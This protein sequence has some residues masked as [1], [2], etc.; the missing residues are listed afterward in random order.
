MKYGNIREEELKNRVE[1]DFFDR[2]DCAAIVGNIDFAVCS[3]NR[4]DSDAEYLLWAEAKAACTDILAMLAQLVL[5]IGKARTFD[6]FLPPAF[7]GC[8]DCEKIAFIPYHEIQDIFYQN[9]FNWKVNSSDITTKEFQQIYGQV[10]KIIENDIPFETYLFD[11]E[12]DEAELRKFIRENFRYSISDRTGISKL[13]IDKNNFITIYQKWA[14]TVKPTI[15]IE[16]DRVKPNGI[17][18][19]AFYLADLISDK[20]TTLLEKLNVVLKSTHYVA[21]RRIDTFGM[22]ASNTI[23]FTD[24]QQA[25]T[26][27]WAKYERPPKED[28]WDYIIERHDLLVPQDVRERKGSFFTPTEWVEL[29]QQYLADVFGEDWQDEY[30]IWDCAA[31]TGNLLA[32]LTNKYNIWASTLD[33]QDV[34]VMHERIKLMNEKSMNG[35]GANLLDDHVFQF[36]FL[37]D[38]FDKL[39][40]GLQRIIK[41]EKLRRRLIIYIN[42]PYAE[43]TNYKGNTKADVARISKISEKYKKELDGAM[44]ELYAQFFIRVFKEIPSATLAAFSKIKYISAPNFK[45]FRQVFTGKFLK[46]FVCPSSTFD[47]VTGNFPVGFSIIKFDEKSALKSVSFDVFGANNEYIGQK[48]FHSDDDKKYINQWIS[49]Y[50]KDGEG[51]CFLNCANNSFQN[52]KYVWISVKEQNTHCA[53]LPLVVDSIIP[54]S[55]YFAVRH[56][57]SA[58]WL[59]DR[60][61]FLFPNKK[62]EKDIDFQNDCLAFMLFHGQNR[63]SC[64][65]GVNHF[66]PFEESEVNARTKYESHIIIS[67]LKGKKIHNAYTD[68]FD[69]QEKTMSK[70]EFSPEAQAVFDAGRELWRYY[71]DRYSI[72][73]K[74]GISEYNVNASLYDIRDYFQGRNE[75]GKMN[76]SSTDEKYNELIGALREKLNLLAKKIEPKVY[77]YEFLMQ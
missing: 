45:K 24:K 76:N 5:T 27:F 55:I 14:K 53:H 11:F 60:D 23:D 63:I 67:F 50:K 38:G 1:K 33:K 9:D 73:L 44:N 30:Y 75:A 43:A 39:P 70:R 41:D 48:Q 16:W 57:I 31:G 25:H 68:L 28:Y 59:N 54:A 29:S 64:K 21:N 15:N 62:W 46:G 74:N 7:L 49:T 77:E 37:N 20:N 56:C 32:N 52:Q 19:G 34:D 17:V 47:N 66:I 3:K 6:K 18:D 40:E 10:K 13:Q 26:Q 72:F 36:D 69:Q 65:D 2:F 4:P 71:H 35:Q 58:T 51:L 22:F 8:F 42:P 61:Q 12:K